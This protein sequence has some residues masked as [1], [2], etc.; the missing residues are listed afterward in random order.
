MASGPL[1]AQLLAAA[2]EGAIC[3]LSAP[4]LPQRE[5]T[6]ETDSEWVVGRCED[7]PQGITLID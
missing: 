6:Q 5:D 1:A 4:L 2:V 7:T 3:S